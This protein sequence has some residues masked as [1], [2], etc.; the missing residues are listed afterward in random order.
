M[1]TTNRMCLQ[2]MDAEL[3]REMKKTPMVEW[4]IPKRVF[5]KKEEGDEGPEDG[6]LV[7]MWD[8][9]S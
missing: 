1:I 2:M 6:L 5:T 8:F 9:S 3:K 4:E 7:E